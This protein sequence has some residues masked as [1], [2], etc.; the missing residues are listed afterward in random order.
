MEK[1][2]VPHEHIYEDK[3]GCSKPVRI[4][5]ATT[6]VDNIP[7]SVEEKMELLKN[8]FMPL[9]Y[10]FDGMPVTLTVELTPSKP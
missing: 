9:L 10:A 1:R 6:E 5:A 3:D 8:A 2:H 4:N 7:L